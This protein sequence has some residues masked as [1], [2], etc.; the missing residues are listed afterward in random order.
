[1]VNQQRSESACVLQSRHYIAIGM[2]R[3]DG[4]EELS[5]FE[6]K[7]QRETDELWI[8]VNKIIKEEGRR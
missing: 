7:F 2:R 3:N 1:M 8:K 6:R 4:A 5:W